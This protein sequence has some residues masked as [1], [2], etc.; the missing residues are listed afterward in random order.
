[1]FFFY[2]LAEDKKSLAPTLRAAAVPLLDMETC[3]MSDVNGG[4]SQSILDTMICAGK[5]NFYICHCCLEMVNV[6]D[7]ILLLLNQFRINARWR[8]RM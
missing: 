7:F 6:N 1:M 3:R 4:R 8:G 2:Y 5:F